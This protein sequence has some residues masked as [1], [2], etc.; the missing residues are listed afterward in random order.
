MFPM[1]I[2]SIQ[3]SELKGAEEAPDRSQIRFAAAPADE[4]ATFHKWNSWQAK[5]AALSVLPIQLKLWQKG[6]V[7]KGTP[8]KRSLLRCPFCRYS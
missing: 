8:G 3:I 4:K 6:N 1:R 7:P 5:L 2:S